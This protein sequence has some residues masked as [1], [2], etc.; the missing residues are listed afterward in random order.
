MSPDLDIFIPTIG[1]PTAGWVWHRGP[2]HSFVAV[3][4]LALLTTLVFMLVKSMRPHKLTVLTAAALGVATHAPLDALTTY[5]TVLFWPFT[6]YRVAI[7]WMPII[8]PIFTF[9]LVGLM[10]V[11]TWRKLVPL[12][13]AACVFGGMYIGFG[14]WQHGRAMQAV[15]ALADARGHVPSRVFAMPSPGALSAWRGL[16]EVNGTLHADGIFVPYVGE[17]RVR[18]GT[19]RALSALIG[20]PESDRRH[21]FDTFSWFSLNTLVPPDESK[22]MLVGDGRYSSDPAGFVPL[23]GLDFT[24]GGEPTRFN[25]R[26]DF[27]VGSLFDAMLGRDERYLPLDT[28]ATTR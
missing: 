17:T 6:D 1:D 7:D 8:D 4:V 5:G 12:S 21:H 15:E 26:G 2:T 22:P 10:I 20:E 25:G 16:Y 11:A 18:V 28:A 14:A 23:W 9:T 3:P 13:I 19:S 27:T 24:G